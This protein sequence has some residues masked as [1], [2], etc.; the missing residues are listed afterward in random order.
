MG[1]K[2]NSNSDDLAAKVA[3]EKH[4]LALMVGI[5]CRGN[6]HEGRSITSPEPGAP[7]LCPG[8]RELVDYAFARIDA[9]PHMQEKTFCSACET[10]CYKPDMRERIRQAMAYAGPR[11]IF[12][13]PAGAIRHL[14]SKRA[15]S[16]R[17]R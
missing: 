5:Y 10:P 15:G 6:R 2:G 17:T 9:C 13:D 1:T 12:H 4:T 16:R 7:D 14:R 11:M 3:R 8:C